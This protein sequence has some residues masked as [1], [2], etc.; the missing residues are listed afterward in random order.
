MAMNQIRVAT[1][2]TY[3]SPGERTVRVSPGTWPVGE[4]VGAVPEAAADHGVAAG[5]ALDMSVVGGGE[6]PAKKRKGD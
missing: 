6:R 4:G 3:T 5:H 1:A 2:Y